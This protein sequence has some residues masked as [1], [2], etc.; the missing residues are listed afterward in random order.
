MNSP[1][2]NKTARILVTDDSITVRLSL[3]DVFE[4]QGYDVMLADCGEAALKL[5][6]SESVDVLVLDLIMPG[7]SGVDVLREIK[8][9]EKTASIPV[10]L[11]TAVS[12]RDELIACMDMGADDFIVKPWNSR[13][14]LGRLRAMVRLK[15]AIDEAVN[16]RRVAE[17]ATESKSVFLANMSHE[18]RT[19]MTAILGYTEN[20]LDTT[21][22]ES[23]RL[24]AVYIIR[25]NGD[26]LL[27]I[28][29]DILDISKI[30]AGKLEVERIPCEPAQL[31]ADVQSLM[32]VRTNERQLTFT[33]QY[34]GL[35]PAVIESDPTRLK[36][37]LINLI[38]NAI[39]FTHSGGVRLAV[40]LLDHQAAGEPMLRFDVIDT[41]I[42]M[43]AEQIGRLFQPFEQASASTT[44]RYGGTG[45]GLMIS[46]RLAN[47]LGGDI[48]VESQP[49]QGSTFR[50]TIATGPL[51]GVKML[52]DPE[53]TIAKPTHDDRGTF[54]AD[55]LLGCRILLADDGPD[56]R[57]L[58]AHILKKAGGEVAVVENGKEAADT[59]LA[60]RD[61]GSPFDVILMD[62]Q[63]PIMDGYE[64]TSLLRKRDYTGQIVALTAHA[65]AS[66]R[67]E[68]IKA[69]CDDYATK[70][71]DRYKLIQTIQETQKQVATTG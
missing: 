44:R 59:A 12:D 55:T 42:G 50:V 19:P 52:D 56:N 38:G 66:A 71:I 2:T 53:S 21:L 16:A 51:D 8:S 64:A 22:L 32:Q 13:E 4:S 46:K 15:R 68:C 48:V 24:D 34:D 40:R 25:R 27:Q 63:M 6:R 54:S 10:L 36:Q 3:R 45:L 18:I 70:P 61:A 9:D 41:G 62:M 26:H 57:R 30:E 39:K 1:Q 7:T 29:N 60:A 58:I 33:T 28:I 43:T 47:M 23:E 11:L 49:G 17:A 35:I 5:I 20:L 37:I 31:L 67:A 14:L 69:G 65:M